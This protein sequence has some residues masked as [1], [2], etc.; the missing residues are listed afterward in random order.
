M[1]V[2]DSLAS[3]ALAV[4]DKYALFTLLDILNKRFFS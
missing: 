3:A 2:S 4:K 1:A